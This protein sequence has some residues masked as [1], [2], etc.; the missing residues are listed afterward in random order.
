M[1]QVKIY[2][3]A[4]AAMER[5]TAYSPEMARVIG[6]QEAVFLMQLLFWSTDGRISVDREGWMYKSA[7]EW[8]DETGLN[9]KQQLIVR[10]NLKKRQLISDRY[11]RL[12]HK[13]WFRLNDTPF[14]TLMEDIVA[15]QKKRAEKRRK[16]GAYPTVGDG[17]IQAKEHIPL[18]EVAPPTVG[19]GHVPLRDFDST[20]KTAESTAKSTLP[21]SLSRER[22]LESSS[23]IEPGTDGSWVGKVQATDGTMAEA[24]T[25]L[26][27]DTPGPLKDPGLARKY[28]RA[29]QGPL[30]DKVIR[31]LVDFYREARVDGVASSTWRVKNPFTLLNRGA[32]DKA[33]TICQ[34]HVRELITEQREGIGRRLSPGT[35]AASMGRVMEISKERWLE[36]AD[37]EQSSTVAYAARGAI[38]KLGTSTYIQRERNRIAAELADNPA[39]LS[40]ITGNKW[41]AVKMF[42]FT[43]TEIVDLQTADLKKYTDEIERLSSYL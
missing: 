16:K 14:E 10:K 17:H 41:D 21:K 12:S 29:R 26:F 28:L 38:L 42:G 40:A 15:A 22:D 8:E 36:C 7:E 30:T 23:K 32:L 18:R 37:R 11:E 33:I 4:V 2:K 20:K 39:W 31:L 35:V 24:F 34:Q 1:K 27:P 6:V 25:K 43:E 9:Y 5:R 13:L 3:D 19:D